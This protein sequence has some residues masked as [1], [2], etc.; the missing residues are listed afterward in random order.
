[1][2]TIQIALPDF[3]HINQRELHM[4]LAAK[5]YEGGTLSIG[6]AVAVAGIF[7]KKQSSRAFNKETLFGSV[8]D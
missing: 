2:Q 6:Q 5:L 7:V 4:M 8:T 3:V 1:M